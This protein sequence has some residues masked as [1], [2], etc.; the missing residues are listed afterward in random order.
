MVSYD[1]C[2]FYQCSSS[3]SQNLVEAKS[4]L[5]QAELLSKA[6]GLIAVSMRQGV[7][8]CVCVGVCVFVCVHV[9]VCQFES[10]S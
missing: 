9:C 1:G 5:G 8:M 4:V 3:V 2:S 10:D 6:Y 7:C